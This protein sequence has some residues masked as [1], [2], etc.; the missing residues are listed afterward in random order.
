MKLRK[1][2]GFVG[3]GWEDFIEYY[4]ISAWHLLVFRYERNSN[5]HIIIFDKTSTETRY[6]SKK[7]VNLKDLV[8]LAELDDTNIS[9]HAKQPESSKMCENTRVV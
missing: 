6:S 2:F 1:T 9:R 4:F 3:D 8:D 5:F 7:N